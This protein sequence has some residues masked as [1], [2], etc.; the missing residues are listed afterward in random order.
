MRWRFMPP[1]K[2]RPDLGKTATIKDRSAYIYAPTEE[3]LATW[4]KEAKRYG[5]PLSRYLVEL[6]DDSMRRSP[7]GVSPRARLERDLAKAS[8]ELAP[9]RKENESLRTLLAESEKSTASYR[10]AIYKVGEQSPD[11]DMLR[12]LVGLFEKKPT[13]RVEEMP[14]ALGLNASDAEGMNR[15]NKALGHLKEI[16][17]LEGDFEEVRCRIGGRKK[18]KV[19]ATVRAA[20]YAKRHKRVLAGL[21]SADDDDGDSEFVPVDTP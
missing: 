8:T 1:T 12:R 14:S 13:W 16:G 10:D 15:L 9:L 3:M 20:R 19:P 2:G 17:V 21:R 5:M 11:Q 6:I 18:H 7:E 4:K